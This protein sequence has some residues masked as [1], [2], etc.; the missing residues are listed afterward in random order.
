[1]IRGYESYADLSLVASYDEGG[2]GGGGGGDGTPALTSGEPVTG[3]SGSRGSAQVFALEVPAGAENLT[4][5]MSGGSGDADLYV[6]HGAEP[7]QDQY[8][9][10]PYEWGNDE[11]VAASPATEGTWY[12]MVRGY[13]DYDGVSLVGSFD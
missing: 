13:R 6:R 2:S 3:L 11:T 10:R 9:Y 1:M 4:F 5:E 7:T 8:D 12:V